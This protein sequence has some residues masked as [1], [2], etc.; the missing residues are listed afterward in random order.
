MSAWDVRA[1]ELLSL[2]SALLQDPRSR[3]HAAA[4]GWLH[5]I[6]RE[7]MYTIDLIEVLLMRWS[8]KGKFKPIPRPWSTAKRRS[9]KR[10]T[11]EEALRILRPHKFKS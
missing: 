6:S 11:A 7:A 8:E 4:A 3:L 1:P 2:F 9:V 10:R 5:P